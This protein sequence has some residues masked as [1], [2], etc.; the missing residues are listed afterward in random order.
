[1]IHPGETEL[2]QLFQHKFLGATTGPWLVDR[3]ERGEDLLIPGA[4]ESTVKLQ[5]KPDMGEEGQGGHFLHHN[6]K[7]WGH[8]VAMTSKR[9]EMAPPN[10]KQGQ[11]IPPAVP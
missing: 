4:A 1:M 3:W 8:K 7:P 5:N 10:E 6:R 11:H 9:L 2:L